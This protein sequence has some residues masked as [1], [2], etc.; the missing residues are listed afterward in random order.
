MTNSLPFP[1]IEELNKVAKESWGE[2]DAPEY[3]LFGYSWQETL[4]RGSKA[5]KA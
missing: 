4:Q 5:R 1:E 3:F 2:P